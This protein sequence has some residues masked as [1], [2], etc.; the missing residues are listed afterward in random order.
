MLLEELAKVPGSI[1]TRLCSP[2]VDKKAGQKE[3]YDFAGSI[4]GRIHRQLII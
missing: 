3:V 4:G 2:F 1:K